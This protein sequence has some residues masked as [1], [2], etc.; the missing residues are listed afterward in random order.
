[1]LC[2]VSSRK[3]LLFLMVFVVPGTHPLYFLH[4]E[5]IDGNGSLSC[6]QKML[7]PWALTSPGFWSVIGHHVV[8][9]PL[10]ALGFLI[11][12]H[13]VHM[14]A[15]HQMLCDNR[16]MW[17]A[18]YD[19]IYAYVWDKQSVLQFFPSCLTSQWDTTVQNP[20]RWSSVRRVTTRNSP[21]S[22]KSLANSENCG[23]DLVMEIW[24]AKWSVDFV[25]FCC[26]LC[27]DLNPGDFMKL[28]WFRGKSSYKKGFDNCTWLASHLFKWHVISSSIIKRWQWEIPEHGCFNARVICID[29][30]F[31][32]AVFDYR[33]PAG[34]STNHRMHRDECCQS[35]IL[36]HFL[37]KGNSIGR[38]WNDAVNSVNLYLFQS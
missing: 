31:S 25:V 20:C 32:I 37:C 22:S 29:G 8:A 18:T 9:V 33:S 38:P 4:L 5:T 26:T 14:C 17:S 35:V 12:I 24:C 34:I 21:K 7:S 30:G 16:H 10:F 15:V 23:L 3:P 28:P 27:S 2:R 13:I 36:W 11:M 6:H 19:I 1:M